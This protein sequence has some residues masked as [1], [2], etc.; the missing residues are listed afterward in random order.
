MRMVRIRQTLKKKFSTPE[1]QSHLRVIC[2]TIGPGK[3]RL[4]GLIGERHSI[5]EAA[6]EM[7]MSYKRAWQLIDT[8]NGCFRAPLVESS[9]GGTRGGGSQLTRAGKQVLALYQ[10]IHAKSM[11]AVSKD[12]KRLQGLLKT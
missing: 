1:K 3:A 12:L 2:A 7:K 6:R 9:T 10:A 4:L 8:L 11:A 5:T